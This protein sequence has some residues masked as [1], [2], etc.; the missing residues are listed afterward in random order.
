MLIT[1]A[2]LPHESFCCGLSFNW[3][4]CGAVDG[5]PGW[6]LSGVE[7]ALQE[8]QCVE[9]GGTHFLSLLSSWQAA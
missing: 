7:P 1:R 6:A 5:G 2:F 8:L 3:S 9:S 4:L